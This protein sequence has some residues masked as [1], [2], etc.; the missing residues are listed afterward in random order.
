MKKKGISILCSCIMSL[1]A[2]QNG[3]CE[4]K[5]ININLKNSANS[6]INVEKVEG[7]KDNTIKGVDISSIIS[8]EDSGVKFYDFNNKEQ[9]I[10][11]TLSQS[12]VN[13]VRVRVWNNPYNKNGNGYG[14]G[15]NDLEKAIKIGKRATENNMK[16]LIDFHYSDF[17]ADP[18][19]QE[20]PKDWKDYTLSQKESAVYDYTKKSL[21]R[22][23][24]E[25]IDIGMVQIGNETNNKF[26]GESDWLSMSRLFNAGSKAVREVNSNILVALHF[27]NPE[28]IGHYENVSRQLYKYNVDYDVFASSYYPFWHG[29]LEN[30]TNELKKVA[31]NYGKKVMVAE[32]SYVYTTE[33]GDGHVNTSPGNN[34]DLNYPISVQGQA[35]SVRNVFQAVCDVGDSGIGVFYW[36]PA[37][38]PVGPKENLEN[39][40]VLWEK[41]GS[42]WASSFAGEY[43]AEDAGKWYGGSAVDNQA[44]FDFNGKPLESLNIFRYIVTGATAPKEIEEIETIKIEVNSYNEIQ[45]PEEINIKFNDSSQKRVRV[46]WN[47]SQLQSIKDKG[48]GCYEVQGNTLSN[49]S[50]INN[51]SVKA[52][53]IIKSKNFVLNPSFE[54]NNMSNWS[55]NYIGNNKN[56]VNIKNEDP[57]SG[58]KA[59][60]FY[61][62]N[63]MNFEIYQNITGLEE[64]KY[65][66]SANIQGGDASLSEMKL[67]AQTSSGEYIEEFI[68]DGWLN[69]K[70][71]I[72]KNIN[73]KDKT[74]KIGIKISAPG[75]AWGTIDDFELIKVCN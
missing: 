12:G 7:I 44:L 11:K 60:H 55:I 33:D 8:L 30:L 46:N 62:K 67:V 25:G 49:E 71:P 57:K 45:L 38:L 31:N 19:K 27:T 75:G 48:P 32:T 29:T 73:I 61:F 10:F 52:N 58:E 17:W 72:I 2:F 54:D 35:T 1:C 47:Q 21:Q 9:D 34:Q 39:N 66:L 6:S 16:V 70:T 41:Y 14:G 15:N 20:A 42:G 4:E 40:K 69:W 64:G 65:Q 74:V 63:N 22:L 23:I 18:A 5:A 43:D 26:I 28:K 13:Y 36:E 59:V 50:Y 56:Y 24:N 37:W 51:L 68:V 53:I 3:F